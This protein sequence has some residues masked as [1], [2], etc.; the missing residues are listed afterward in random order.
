MWGSAWVGVASPPFLSLQARASQSN[1]R[2]MCPLARLVQMMFTAVTD[3]GVSLG[4]ERGSEL[5]MDGADP[6]CPLCNK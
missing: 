2:H 3:D 1:L 5:M 4:S 6:A